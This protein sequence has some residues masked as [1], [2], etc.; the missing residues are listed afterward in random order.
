MARAAPTPFEWRANYEQQGR[1]VAVVTIL[2][3]SHEGAS[4]VYR[5]W[6]AVGE[7]ED[8][9]PWFYALKNALP[10]TIEVASEIPFGEEAD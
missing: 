3:S 9:V 7:L 1:L 5:D 10:V 8:R 4:V 2:A 6:M